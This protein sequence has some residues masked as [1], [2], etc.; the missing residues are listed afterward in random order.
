[1]NTIRIGIIASIG[2][3]L[4]S[5]CTDVE[6]DSVLTSGMYAGIYAEAA[7]DGSVSLPY[8]IWREA[9]INDAD[10]EL[11]QK[12]YD[13]LNP[14]PYKTLQDKAS[15]KHN[16]AEIEVGKSFINCQ[17]DT[18]MPQS[19]PWHPR[20]SEKLGL[21]RLVEMP[22]SHEVCFTNPG[23]LAEKIMEAGRD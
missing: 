17:Q 11:A 20:L 4:A 3:A 18:S 6:S 19:L 14:H 5:A 10:G 9:F 22:G 8:P 1:M 7:G 16:I 23:L 12:A 2:I 21:F 15:L 13:S